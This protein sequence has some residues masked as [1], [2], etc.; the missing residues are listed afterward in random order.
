MKRTHLA[1]MLCVAAC[2]SSRAALAEPPPPPDVTVPVPP[3]VRRYVTVEWSPLALFL[4]KISA[5]VVIAPVD[6]HSIVLSPFYASTTTIP[7]Y[8]Y[9]NGGNPTQLP[10]QTFKGG[11]GELGYRYYFGRGGPRGFFVG[12]SLMF[13]AFT[14]TAQNGADTQFFNLGVAADVGFQAL[15]LDRISLSLGAGAQYNATTTTIPNQQFPADVFANSG[16]RPRLL[17]SVGCAF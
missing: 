1:A 9:D 12:P 14:A 6:H 2:L 8:I 15:V 13:G 4:G 7:I 10:Q 11:G 5:N 17:A 3:P 16:V